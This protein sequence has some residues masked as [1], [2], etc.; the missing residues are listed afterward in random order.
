MKEHNHNKFNLCYSKKPYKITLTIKNIISIYGND[1]RNEIEK[2]QKKL[3]TYSSK[4]EK[5]NVV[6]K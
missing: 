2:F 5:T 4:H 6:T 1:I 3:H